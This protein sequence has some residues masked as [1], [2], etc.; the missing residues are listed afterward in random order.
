MLVLKESGF[1]FIALSV[2][3]SYLYLLYIYNLFH[4]CN[5]FFILLNI[6][7]ALIQDILITVSHLP[8]SPN[9]FPAPILF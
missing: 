7:S 9:S 2:Y 1:V 8:A 5:S 4:F 6:D 3:M